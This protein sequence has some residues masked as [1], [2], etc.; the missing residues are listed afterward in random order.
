MSES[1]E[2]VI[3]LGTREELYLESAGTRWM[4][5]FGALG[6]IS[7]GIAFGLG[8][9]MHDHLRQFFF[10]Y[11]T[12]WV[13]CFAIGASALLFV[14]GHHLFRSTWSV[15]VR[16]LAEGLAGN[17]VPL[18][19]LFIPI[20]FGMRQLYPWMSATYMNS[21]PDLHNKI[22]YL[23]PQFF[24]IRM[25]LYAVALIGISVYMRFASLKQDQ[26]GKVR[27][28]LTLQWNSAWC[29][30]TIFWV[31][32]MAGADLLMTLEPTWITYIDPG[33]FFAA[34]A[35]MIYAVLPLLTMTL[36]AGGRLK[37][38]V[39]AEHYE[40]MGRWLFAWA[41]FWT[42]L[43][44]AQ[45]MLIWYANKPDETLN[46]LVRDMGPWLVL[47]IALFL[48]HFIIPLFG[49]LPR[50][51][52]RKKPLLAF[53]C[54]WLLFFAY[55]DFFEQIQPQVWSA[56]KIGQKAMAGIHK[57][58]PYVLPHDL[59]KIAWLPLHPMALATS[60]LCLMGIGSLFMAHTCYLLQRGSLI[61]L[62]D[63]KLPES[64]AFENF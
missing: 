49:M 28:L 24:Y 13:F 29:Y 11:L 58:N 20:I 7:L 2:Q 57:F 46:Y 23:N 54:I 52:K 27:R 32:N 50:Q 8:M 63:P 9:A 59:A 30:L 15:V 25:A 3:K 55:L 51:S 37:N 40:D 6:V 1:S 61:P 26:D 5:I 41:M 18:L 43:G 31:I 12:A 4:G 47:T 19:V 44:F 64:L 48:G 60:L 10:S 42:Y 22:G 16:R 53:W 45:Y 34:T 33:F 62:K 35:M 38:A 21:T 14:I 17:F 56:T 39:S 36:Q